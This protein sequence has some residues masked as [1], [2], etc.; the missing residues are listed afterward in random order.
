MGALWPGFAV[1]FRT[2][3]LLVIFPLNQ[4]KKLFLCFPGCLWQSGIFF[5]K[6]E[7]LPT[8]IA[9]RQGKGYF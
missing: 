6:K 3:R 8:R 1:I 7:T 4:L 5:L 9:R 2:F